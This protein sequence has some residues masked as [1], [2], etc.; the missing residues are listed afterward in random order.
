MRIVRAYVF[1]VLLYDVESWTLTDTWLERLQAF[2]GH[3]EK[4]EVLHII[5]QGKIEVRE[6]QDED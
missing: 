4:Y 1:K 2:M 3:S 6:A 5:T